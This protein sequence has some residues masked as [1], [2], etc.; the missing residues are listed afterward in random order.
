MPCFNAASTLAAS[1]GSL[2]SQS[3]ADWELLAVDDGSTDGTAD[4]LTAF[5]DARIRL[6]QQ[7]NAGVSAARNRALQV[8]QSRFV[9]FLDADDTWA[10]SF[11]DEMLTALTHHPDA[12]LAYCGW[13]NLG[14]APGRCQP[15]VPPDYEASPDKVDVL[16]RGCP[17]P[18]HAALCRRDA[19]QRTGGFDTRLVV[20]EDFLLWLEMAAEQP[21]VRVPNVLAFYHHDPARTQATSD[22]GRAAQQIFTAQSIFLERH[23]R[24]AARLG[25]SRVRDLTLGSMLQRAYEQF[26]ARDLHSA[27]RLFRHVLLHGYGQLRD[28]KYM[29]PAAL[30]PAPLYEPFV[31]W[32]DRR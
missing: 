25:R 12:V 29:A 18:I 28:W 17:W 23:P 10:A 1:V 16:L 21:I 14:L 5:G 15:Y 9:A 19:L 8:A 26:W 3:F 13:Q 30:L 31:R 24:I 4:A 32:L 6:L 2:L 7:A 22:R 20:A 11:L 27:Q